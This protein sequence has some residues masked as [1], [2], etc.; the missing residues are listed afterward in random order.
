MNEIIKMDKTLAVTRFNQETFSENYEYR[1]KKEFSGC[2]YGVPVKISEKIGSDNIIIVIEMD[3]TKGVKNICGIGLVK[4]NLNRKINCK[5]YSNNRYNK[6]TYY[7]KYRIDASE[8]NENELTILNK[9]SDILFKTKGHVQRGNGITQIPTKNIKR[10]DFDVSL[11]NKE[12][13]ENFIM[14]M[15]TNRLSDLDM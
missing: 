1:R 13:I 14:A 15:F 9:V 8:F 6:Y 12:Y 5:I 2:I 7:S 3:I 10:L 11:S 4:N